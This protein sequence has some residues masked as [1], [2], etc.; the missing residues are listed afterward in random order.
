MHSRFYVEGVILG[1]ASCPEIPMPNI[2]LPWL[3]KQKNSLVAGDE[4]TDSL[5]A[6]F[7]HCLNDM[8]NN[9]LSLPSYV[10]YNDVSATNCKP[11]DNEPMKKWCEGILTAHGATQS[12]WQSAW[13]RMQKADPDRAP[14]LAKELKRCL[15][16]FST[17][18]DPTKKINQSANP[19]ELKKKLPVIAKSLDN[20]LTSYVR[21][22]GEL[23]SYLPNQFETFA[24]Q[25]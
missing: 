25:Q 7:K 11:Q 10:Y 15:N 18:A 8:R 19:E 4:I 16:M 9:S 20:S 1:A 14:Q 2:W 21:V 17:F 23:A 12:S 3:Y 5:F 24:Q 6:Y 22:S 13:N